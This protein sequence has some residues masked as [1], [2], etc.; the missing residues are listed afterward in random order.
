[1][2]NQKRGWQ[3]IFSS[4]GWFQ[5]LLRPRSQ[6]TERRMTQWSWR[7]WSETVICCKIKTKQNAHQCMLSVTAIPQNSVYHVIQWKQDIETSAHHI[8]FSLLALSLMIMCF[9]Q[10]Y[11]CR[12]RPDHHDQLFGNV[13]V[14]CW[15]I[16]H[17]TQH[18]AGEGVTEIHTNHF[19]HQG[20]QK[21]SGPKII[22]IHSRRHECLSPIQ[23]NGIVA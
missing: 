9:G 22:S 5:L 17:R 19:V 13:Y 1:M 4:F 2:A 6:M 7:R 12:L 11:G 15:A 21:D 18:I 16:S 3:R 20:I 10:R 23:V 14:L 8:S